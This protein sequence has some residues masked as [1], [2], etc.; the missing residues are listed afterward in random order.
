MLLHTQDTLAVSYEHIRNIQA[1]HEREAR[2][3]HIN[4]A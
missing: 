4:R 3:R 1:T 2:R